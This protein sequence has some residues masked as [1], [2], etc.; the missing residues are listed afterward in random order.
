MLAQYKNI[1]ANGQTDLNMY[2]QLL[3]MNNN[4]ASLRQHEQMTIV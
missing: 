3:M 1:Y 4:H 2:G